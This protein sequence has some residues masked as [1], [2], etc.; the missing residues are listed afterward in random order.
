MLQHNILTF[1][2]CTTGQSSKNI[3]LARSRLGVG[4]TP[5]GSFKRHNAVPLY[6]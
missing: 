3:L 5:G 4:Y 6:P 2:A 1:A